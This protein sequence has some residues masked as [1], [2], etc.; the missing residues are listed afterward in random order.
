MNNFNDWIIYEIYLRSF[1]DSNGDGIGDFN[2]VRE[3]LDYLQDLGVNTLWL[4]PC[5]KSPNYDNGYDI[6]DYKDVS[7]E[8][9]SMDELK[10]LLDDVH[11]RGM[12]LI[13]DLV[14]NHTS[15]FHPWFQEAKKSKD[16]P[17][18]DYYIWV[19]KPPNKWQSV[20]GG[21]AWE[22]NQETDEYYLHSF[23][24]EQADLNWD[25]PKVRKE[26]KKIVEFW[27]E[28]GVDGFRCD[29]LDFISKDLHS[30]KM[31]DGPN[32]HEYIRELF[33]GRKLKD[34][35]TIGE[36]KSKAD[37]IEK[38]CGKDRKELTTVFQFDHINLGVK[39][40][41]KHGKLSLNKLKKTL[42][43]W[44]EFTQHKQLYYTLFTDNHD[45]PYYLSRITNGENRYQVAT[46]LCA[47]F[48]LLKGIPVLYQTQEYGAINPIY[49]DIKYFNDVE[50]IHY[51]RANKGDKK[52]L[53]KI[54]MGSRD[55]TRR[56]FAWSNKK[57][58]NYGFSDGKPWLTLNSNAKEINLEKDL[59]SSL[60]V[61]HFYKS[62]L[63]LRNN[64]DCIRYGDFINLCKGKRNCFIYERKY[65]KQSIIVVCNFD[66]E[67]TILL[68]KCLQEDNYRLILSN[69]P[70][71]S[72]LDSQFQSFE[73]RVFLKA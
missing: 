20:F 43:K 59:K 66:K 7:P 61:F 51:F 72:P 55:N 34:I 26:C 39:D 48:Y 62:V 38:I 37:N 21:S 4:S 17:Y 71:C 42:V 12:K 19:K 52:L 54:N 1:K 8:F 22:Y 68:P 56:P 31:Y 32:L 69:I 27:V 13:M 49:N 67:K 3:K 24:V 28:F 40:K 23:A 5:Y 46:M 25:N 64:Y 29:V 33:S 35:F 18:H 57:S 9:G 60:S 58:D 63:S 2:G 14:L 30:K 36:C 6:A 50:T 70:D 10:C 41:Y 11:K 16:S 53:E 47:C 15:V 44:Q 65:E 73:V 45:Q